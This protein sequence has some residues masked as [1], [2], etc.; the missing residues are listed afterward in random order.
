METSEENLTGRLYNETIFSAVRYSEDEPR[1]VSDYR[2]A[3]NKD[4][5]VK[6]SHNEQPRVQQQHMQPQNNHLTFSGNVFFKTLFIRCIVALNSSG[7]TRETK[8]A[9]NSTLNRL[10]KPNLKKKLKIF[11]I[12]FDILWNNKSN[13]Y[14]SVTISEPNASLA[15][16]VPAFSLTPNVITDKFLR[17]E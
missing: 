6:K 11:F 12:Y 14:E 7:A 9:G 13:L 1:F 3:F 5:S 10:L 2:L 8:P 16:G 4:H 17:T 15:V